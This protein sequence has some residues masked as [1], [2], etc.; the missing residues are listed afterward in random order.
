MSTPGEQPNPYAQ[1]ASHPY[2]Q[3][4]VGPPSNPYSVPPQHSASSGPYAGAPGQ[5][6]GGQPGPYG[7]GGGPPG[8]GP[9]GSGG[10][11]GHPGA[12]GAPRKGA[13]G[14]LW[15]LVGLVVASAV[16]AGTLLVLGGLPGKD[17]DAP[18][19]GSYRFHSDLCV[20]AD[21]SAVEEHYSRDGDAPPTHYS[22]QHEARDESYCSYSLDATD[23][24]RYDYTYLSISAYWH[25]ALDPEDEF[26][27]EWLAYEQ[28]TDEKNTYTVEQVQEI[29]QEAYLVTQVAKESDQ[30][31]Y[32]TLAVRDGGL[33]ISMSWQSYSSEDSEPPSKDTLKEMLEKDVRSTLEKLTEP[34]PA[35]SES[36]DEESAEGE[37]DRGT[38]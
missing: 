36:P 20:S 19:L 27:A 15:G 38:V 29:G 14:W 8:F 34:D 7:P 2:H 22:S 18:S 3:P 31:E 24:A 21:I 10:G 9:V 30:P 28:R 25:K 32:M 35:A 37:D 1:P 5:P 17:D 6:D 11:P 23:A 26:A 4:S 16:W 33:V 13:P 12:P